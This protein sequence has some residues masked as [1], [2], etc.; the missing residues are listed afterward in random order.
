MVQ[1]PDFYKSVDH[2]EDLYKSNGGFSISRASSTR[3]TSA[4]IQNDPGI[5]INCKLLII[6]ILTMVEA[7][8]GV[9][10]VR[11]RALFA[12][13]LRER[14]EISQGLASG[15]S[16]REIAKGL[17]RAVS[18]VGREV[19]RLVFPHLSIWEAGILSAIL[20]PTDAGLGQVIVNSPGV[21]MRIRQALNVEAGLNDGLS[22]P[23]LLFFIVL[24]AAKTEGGRNSLM[25]FIV[26]QLGFG[27]L[28]GLA[29]GLAGGWLLAL[30]C[31]KEW[32]SACSSRLSLPA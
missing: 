29:I 7:G 18:T 9:P 19:A 28:M 11:R 14:E 23:F 13:T 25:Q 32:M 24:A 12:L 17:E 31:R 30:A 3:P 2:K 26:E 16:I 21:P 15:S 27:A 5:D 20:A 8:G 22:V 6:N 10:A 1:N 4:S